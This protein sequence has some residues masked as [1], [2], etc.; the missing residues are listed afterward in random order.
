MNHYA[1]VPAVLS[2]PDPPGKQLGTESYKHVI[3]NS[4]LFAKVDFAFIDTYLHRCPVRVVSKG[5]LLL[6]PGQRNENVYLVLSGSMSVNLESDDRVALLNL[7]AGECVGEMSVIDD[8][9]VCAYVVAMEDTRL[10]V[11]DRS[12]MWHMI[13]ALH[14]VSFNLLCVFSQRLRNDNRVML[15]SVKL[16]I[17]FE[18]SAHVDGL[19][20]VHNRRWMNEMFK[21]QI[22]RYAQDR[23]PLSL[24]MVD[25]DHFKRFNDQYGHVAGDRALY[26][27]G[28][29]LMST[30][31]PTDLLARFGGEEFAIMLPATGLEQAAS[32]A[33]RLCQAVAGT[34]I[35]GIDGDYLPALTTSIG[36]AQMSAGETL[37]ALIRVADTALYRAKNRGRNQVGA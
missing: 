1:E 7:G 22:E 12:L 27:I 4:P 11:I 6:Q 33:Q 9:P 13:S 15:D 17:Q 2:V 32:I 30:L 20:G 10:L 26:G 18:R 21:R 25:I 37:E 3:E 24:L 19:T 16:Q 35:S 5:E 14:Q 28:Q 36:V 34:P 23:S 31:R 29:T 8:N